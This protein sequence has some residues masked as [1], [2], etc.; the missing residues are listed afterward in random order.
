[1]QYWFKNGRIERLEDELLKRHPE[2]LDEL[3]SKGYIRIMSENDY[4]PFK[5]KT[6]KSVAK[7]L[8]KKVKKK[9]K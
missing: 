3:K 7:K 2:K 9:K 4:S 8:V 5:K 6:V 1:M